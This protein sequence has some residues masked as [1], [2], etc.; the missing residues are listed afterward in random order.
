M[1]KMIKAFVM[2]IDG[3]LTDGG[4]YIGSKKVSC[5]RWICCT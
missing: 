3:T 4:L 5:K 1:N 2:D